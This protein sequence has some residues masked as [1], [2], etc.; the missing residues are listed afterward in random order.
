MVKVGDIC[1]LLESFA[2]LSLQEP[3]DNAGLILGNRE[4]EVTGVLISLDA[5]LEVIDEAIALGYNM[6]VTHHPFI[7]KGL[8]TITGKNHTEDCLIKAIKKD[9]I[10]YAGHTNMDAV[11][12]GVNERIADKLGLTHSS[13]LVPGSRK[14]LDY[15]LGMIGIL[16]ETLSETEF[17]NLVKQTFHCQGIRHSALRGKD[18]R[19]VALCGGSGSEFLEDALLAGADVFLTGEA[20]YHEFF[21]HASDILLVDAG[22]YETE[23]FTKEVFFELISKKLP[24][25]AVR[26]SV[27]ETNPV[28]YL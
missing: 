15:G 5:T 19:K 9:I 7:F 2:P 28:H 1:T 12:G 18:I 23:Q 13:I 24:T 4:T 11:R 27:V 20:K 17:L 25:F 3:Y 22:H 8:R 6:I 14:D 21:T 26:I 16:S 10:L